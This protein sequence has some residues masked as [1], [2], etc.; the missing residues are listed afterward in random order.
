MLLSRRLLMKYS[1]DYLFNNDD[2][3]DVI[4]KVI[5]I[6]C[7]VILEH[8]NSCGSH[9]LISLN[10]TE[11]EFFVIHRDLISMRRWPWLM[12]ADASRCKPM[13]VHASPLI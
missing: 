4:F 3:V 9:T 5:F 1:H 13:Q 7:N 10:V 8:N 12:Q 6:H 2:L 11:P